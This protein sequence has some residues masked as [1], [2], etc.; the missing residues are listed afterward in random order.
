MMRR[1]NPFRPPVR[2]INAAATM[3]GQT[4]EETFV[5]LHERSGPAKYSVV[6][7]R[8]ALEVK[9]RE[10]MVLVWSSDGGYQYYTVRG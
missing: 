7:G 6:A 9:Q 4:G 2:F 3:A 5:V 8:E 10:G 1:K